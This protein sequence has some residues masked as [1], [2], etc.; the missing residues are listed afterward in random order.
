V[1][2]RA[3]GGRTLGRGEVDDVAVAL[4]HIDLLNLRDGL[5]VHLLEG[6]LKLLV[7][8]ARGLV[9]LLDL[10]SGC[11]LAATYCVSIL[12]LMLFPYVRG[13][14]AMVWCDLRCAGARD[15]DNLR[16][17]KWRGRV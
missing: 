7:V 5:Y 2:L 10:S 15:V 3:C 1:A 11:T 12:L 4:K 17:W 16:R 6:G 14:R 8:G 13:C 9:H